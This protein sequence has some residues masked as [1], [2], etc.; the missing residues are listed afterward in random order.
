MSL[1]ILVVRLSYLLIALLSNHPCLPGRA[2]VTSSCFLNQYR[3]PCVL[4]SWCCITNDHK[5]SGLKHTHLSPPGVW[6]WLAL[7]SGSHQLNCDVVYHNLTTGVKLLMLTVGLMLRGEE[8]AERGRQRTAM[9]GTIS[10]FFLTHP[11]PQMSIFWT[12]NG[13]TSSPPHTTS[14]QFGLENCGSSVCK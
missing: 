6:P 3:F 1:K 8:Y 10:E 2:G 13:V 12:F 4:A 9:L 11:K 5:L 14:H 7:C